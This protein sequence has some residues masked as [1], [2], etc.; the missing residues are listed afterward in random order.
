MENDCKFEIPE[1][2]REFGKTVFDERRLVANKFVQEFAKVC[3][4]HS[5]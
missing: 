1:K 4:G 5:V 2:C 3:V